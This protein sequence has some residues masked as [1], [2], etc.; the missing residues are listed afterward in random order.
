MSE[1]KPLSLYIHWPFCLSKCPYC[2]FNSHV[3][4][5]IAYADWERAYLK[6][7]DYF[8]TL[9]C[10]SQ[11]RPQHIIKTIFFG[12]G[13]PS[14]M[15]PKLVA[16]ILSKIKDLWEV[17]S[18]LEIT[19]E[20]NPTSVEIEKFKALREAGVNRVS[21][22]V[23]SFDQEALTFLGREHGADQAK[24]AIKAARDIFPRY[25]FDLIYAR[26][27]QG[28]DAWKEELEEALVFKPS[29]LSLYQLT[30]E[31]GTAF[32][33]AYQAGRFMMPSD[34]EA[35][36]LYDYTLER[37][38]AEGLHRYEISNY[39][40]AGEES[41]HNLVYWRYDDYLGIG[42]GAH[43]RITLGGQK[44]ALHNHRAPEIYLEKITKEGFAHKGK[45]DLDQNEIFTE[46]LMMG[47]RLKEGVLK[48]A[49]AAK[50]GKAFEN[51]I[52]QKKLASLCAGGLMVQDDTSIKCTD[53]GLLLLNS[54]IAEFI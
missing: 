6:E 23:Q 42:P 43:G 27:G 18:D 22:G 25:S 34:D 10:D 30:I 8:Y 52:D 44:Y 19:L 20:A 53:Q 21:I 28:L 47:L 31:K 32:Y 48:S 33:T 35:A 2:D 17:D 3:R 26:P 50:T 14:L 12:G 9:L 38:R 5:R 39:A 16:S 29:H 46:M 51:W 40:K 49:F 37:L 11:D 13:T 24:R 15:P 41:K 45:I 1:L 7:I 54:V 36:V 4:D